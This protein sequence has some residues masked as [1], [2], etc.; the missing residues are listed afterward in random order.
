MR[1][2]ARAHAERARRSLTRLVTRFVTNV[3]IPREGNCI[4]RKFALLNSKVNF[5][6]SESIRFQ[7][8][9][10]SIGR[11]LAPRSQPR[12]S[13]SAQ[14]D[15]HHTIAIDVSSATICYREAQQRRTSAMAE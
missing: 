11:F 7:R 2:A 5:A 14:K 6:D 10:A 15:R 12:T 9:S 4:C 8:L 3:C 1:R 13:S